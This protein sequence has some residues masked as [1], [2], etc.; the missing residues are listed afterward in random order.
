ML[1]NFIRF[2]YKVIAFTVFCFLIVPFLFW[3]VGSILSDKKSETGNK[4]I[5]IKNRR[6]PVGEYRKALQDSHLQFIVDFVEQNRISNIQHFSAYSNWLSQ[7]QKRTNFEHLAIKSIL[8]QD[9]A[10]RYGLS[11]NLEEVKEWIQ[12]FPLFKGPNGFFDLTIYNNLIK[13]M[14][15]SW[16]A[17]F[18]ESMVR[19]LTVKKLQNFIKNTVSASSK[20]VLNAYIE[21]NEKRI[22]YYV[23]KDNSD[24]TGKVKNIPDTEISEYF[25][26][27][28][29]EFREPDK[30]KV[31]FLLFDPETIKTG[32]TIGQKEIEEYYSANEKQYKDK[33]DKIKK[34]EEVKQEIIDALLK[35]KAQEEAY[36]RAL[37]ASLEL[38]EKHHGDMVRLAEKKKWALDESDFF[39][40][41]GFIPQLGW[42]PQLIESIWDMELNT[43]SNPLRIGEKWVIVSPV[44]EKPSQ[45]PELSNVKERIVNLLKTQKAKELALE[46][47]E[48]NTKEI[49]ERMSQKI[50]FTIAA[51]SLGLKVIKTK[52]FISTGTIPKLG[53]AE[54][55]SQAAFSIKLRDIAGPVKISG[56]I[57]ILSLREIQ[58]IDEEK[59]ESE[60]A[61]FRKT[62][63]EEKKT[64]FLNDWLTSLVK[65][66]T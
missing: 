45:I 66:Y 33:E 10:K 9:E 30:I 35:E 34:L 37:E 4:T 53:Q 5:S 19:I 36:D 14:F 40:K 41:T 29:E 28:K 21:K 31:S 1:L 23:R 3:G 55:F 54:E 56:G 12:E 11:S 43:I 49:E 64:K 65:D 62:Y 15:R 8:L 46:E 48:K 39:A 26:K 42:A 38:T 7:L 59:W 24:Y 63:L 61:Q 2:R 6:V 52:P 51:K 22:V 18:E 50:P 25:D 57:A 32:I 44:E 60:K 13:N 20:E 58:H 17:Q 47:A 27:N 16:P